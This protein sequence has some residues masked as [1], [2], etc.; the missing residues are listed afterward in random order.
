MSSAPSL[1]VA[2][3]SK[4]YRARPVLHEVSFAVSPGEAIAL[5]GPNGAGK[6][7]LLGCITGDRVP[8]T[9]TVHVC[10]GDP[11]SDHRAAARCMGVVPEQPVLYGELSVG[12]MLQFAHAAREPAPPVGEA[13]R[14]LELLGLAGAESLLCRELSQGMGRKLALVLALVHR[15]RLIVL[16]EATNG[17]DAVSVQQLGE[18]LLR[19]RADGAAVLLASH[20]RELVAAWCERGI[21]LEPGARHTLFAS[22]REI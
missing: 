2:G 13:D 6:S 22:T 10:G 19:R 8:E 17:L 14:L 18:E 12:E 15:P 16:D 20:D 5:V 4:S 1:V 11:L 21:R 9:G 3:I 7:T